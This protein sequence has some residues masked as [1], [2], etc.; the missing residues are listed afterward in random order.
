MDSHSDKRIRGPFAGG[1]TSWKSGFAY[2]AYEARK[3]EQDKPTTE[4]ATAWSLRTLA[5]QLVVNHEDLF[6]LLKDPRYDM[7][8]MDLIPV[9]T[10]QDL[11]VL[12]SVKVQ[13]ARVPEHHRSDI[14]KPMAEAARDPVPYANRPVPTPAPEQHRRESYVSTSSQPLQFR[15]MLADGRDADRMLHY[16]ARLHQALLA[17]T[18]LRD[19]FI[20]AQHQLKPQFRGRPWDISDV[21]NVKALDDS[22]VDFSATYPKD[23]NVDA[24]EAL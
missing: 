16:L 21:H 13:W 19:P 15:K 24:I 18:K 14:R 11:E 22:D 17:G 12:R 20:L 23:Q 8:R 10:E 5:R 2:E 6:T 4:L 1:A 7:P 9:N 3:R